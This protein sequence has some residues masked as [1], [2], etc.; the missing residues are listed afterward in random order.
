MYVEYVNDKNVPSKL[1]FYFKVRPCQGG[2]LFDPKYRVCNR[3]ESIVLKVNC[4]L[5]GT[6]NV[7][8]KLSMKPKSKRIGA[9]KKSAH[10]KAAHKKL[11]RPRPAKS[12][13]IKQT[14]DSGPNL[15]FKFFP[16]R[17]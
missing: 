13:Q 10:K 7:I 1:I 6:S 9:H 14:S 5:R 8:E 17:S 15:D 16:I 4:K 2:L 3:P 12:P 11:K